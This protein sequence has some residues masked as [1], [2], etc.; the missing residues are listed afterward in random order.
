M[1]DSHM[2]ESGARCSAMAII[3]APPRFVVPISALSGRP[4]AALRFLEKTIRWPPCISW[5]KNGKLRRRSADA[6][7]KL[8]AGTFFQSLE[9]LLAPGTF[10]RAWSAYWHLCPPYDMIIPAFDRTLLAG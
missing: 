1:F 4:K 9:C 8:F 10:F 2:K 5:K 7:D 6:F 3:S